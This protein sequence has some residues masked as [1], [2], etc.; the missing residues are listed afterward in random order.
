LTESIL[1][2]LM[3]EKNDL[4]EIMEFVRKNPR[5]IEQTIMGN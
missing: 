3:V 2:K 5:N 4:D 1:L